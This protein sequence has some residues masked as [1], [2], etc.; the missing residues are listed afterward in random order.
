MKLSPIAIYVFGFCLALA[1]LS[2][3]IVTFYM[4]DHTEGVYQKEYADKLQIEADKLPAA[5]KRVERA[6]EKRAQMET[7]WSWPKP[8]RKPFRKAASTSRRTDIS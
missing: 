4:P 7:D 1:A 5:N 6:L 8:R 3:G 2:V